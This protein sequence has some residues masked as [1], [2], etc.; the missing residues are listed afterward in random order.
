MLSFVEKRLL[1]PMIYMI[2]YPI[3]NSLVC[4]LLRLPNL[5]SIQ[6]LIPTIFMNQVAFQFHHSQLPRISELRALRSEHGDPLYLIRLFVV[7]SLISLSRY[8][9][10]SINPQNI[11]RKDF[12]STS[13]SRQGLK[14]IFMKVWPKPRNPQFDLVAPALLVPVRVYIRA[15]SKDTTSS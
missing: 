13:R 6:L 15:M 1:I 3:F 12:R 8:L 10:P 4:S 5:K 14:T 7:S 9:I 11:R 2:S